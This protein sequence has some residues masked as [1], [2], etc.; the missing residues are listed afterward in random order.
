MYLASVPHA[1]ITHLVP[2]TYYLGDYPTQLLSEATKGDFEVCR[3]AW[4]VCGAARSLTLV[5]VAGP[6]RGAHLGGEG[7][8]RRADREQRMGTATHLNGEL[9]R[10]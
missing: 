4:V 8:S 3:S 5:T 7:R 1:A 6:R 9:P 10:G 2:H